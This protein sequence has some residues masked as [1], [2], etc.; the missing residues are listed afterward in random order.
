MIVL[1]LIIIIILSLLNY[2]LVIRE[3]F[4]DK[5]TKNFDL[6]PKIFLL[7]SEGLGLENKII[8]F[9][10]TKIKIFNKNKEVI[11]T[12]LSYT[13]NSNKI[14]NI[15][16][17]RNKFKTYNLL[18]KNGIPT[19]NFQYFQNIIPE[20]RE[21]VIHK[22][23]IKYPIVAKII[24]GANGDN[25]YVDI[26]NNKE[27]TYA[28]DQIINNNYRELMIEEFVKGNDHRILMFNN[29]IMDIICRIPPFVI[30]DGYQSINHLVK[31]K[32]DKRRN[33]GHR[34]IQIDYY[35]L[36]K[37]N[38]NLEYVPKIREKIVVN[39][40]SN[41]HKG[42]NLDRINIKNVHPDNIKLFAKISRV[43]NLNILGIDF[44]TEDISKSYKIK[45]KINEINGIPNL[46]LHYYANNHKNTTI[47]RR[48]LK[49]YFN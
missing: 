41:F 3:S 17:A 27:L 30:G 24:D 45:G 5:R 40:L 7:E 26:K 13:F 47:H 16:I 39:P 49:E 18:R 20:T 22:H 9:N 2:Y 38:F 35:Y 14:S 8:S 46:D 12:P 4:L 33:L 31:I 36:K 19:P 1:Y 6:I 23:N 48:I 34:P 28:I 29:K 44:I 37:C 43:M 21:M 25:V 15:K 11:I 32:N 10:P 42:A